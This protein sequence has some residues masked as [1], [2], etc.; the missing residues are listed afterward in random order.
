MPL[1]VSALSRNCACTLFSS[2]RQTSGVSIRRA[3]SRADR[4]KSL[5]ECVEVYPCGRHCVASCRTLYVG[6]AERE[7][8]ERGT[9]TA[10]ASAGTAKLGEDQR[11]RHRAGNSCRVSFGNF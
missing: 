10:P 8:R 7:Q 3:K 1:V 2:E 9:R 11:F 6:A 4:L 5:G